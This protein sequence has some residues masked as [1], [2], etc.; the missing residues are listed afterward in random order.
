MKMLPVTEG[1]ARSRAGPRWQTFAVLA[2][3]PLASFARASAE[4]G[5]PVVVHA[6]PCLGA[7]SG[8]VFYGS[9][10]TKND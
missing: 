6:L 7:F 2:K 5:C 1:W 3:C 8:G 9:L 10:G 4:R